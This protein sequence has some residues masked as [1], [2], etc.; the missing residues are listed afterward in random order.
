MYNTQT[1]KQKRNYK[2]SNGDDG[3]LLKIT[4]DNTGTFLAASCSDKTVSIIDYQSGEIVAT[5]VGHSEVVTGLK[6]TNDGSQL[7]SVS[8]DGWVN[9]VSSSLQILFHNKN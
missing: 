1:A 3:F 2:G 6:F 5:L 4:I 9:W 7:I 8:A